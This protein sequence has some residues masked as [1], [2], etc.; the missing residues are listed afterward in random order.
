MDCLF[1]GNKNVCQPLCK[2]HIKQK[3]QQNLMKAIVHN[4]VHNITTELSKSDML[5]SYDDMVS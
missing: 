3:S 5:V 2:D 4:Y 1:T